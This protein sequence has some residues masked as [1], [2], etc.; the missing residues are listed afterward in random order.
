MFPARECIHILAVAVS[1]GTIAVVDLS[2]L[3]LG[4]GGKAASVRSR[5]QTVDP[6]QSG[7]RVF[8]ATSFLPPIPDYYYLNQAFQVKISA[9]TG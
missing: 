2:L 7:P 1:I 5:R 8:L 4:F 6:S 3:N 9:L